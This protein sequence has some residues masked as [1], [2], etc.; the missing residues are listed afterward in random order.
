MNKTDNVKAARCTD[1]LLNYETVVYFSQ[2][3]LEVQRYSD[4]VQEY[5]ASQRCFTDLHLFAV[6]QSLCHFDYCLPGPYS[7][8][9]AYSTAPSSAV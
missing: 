5:Q 2:E 6:T 8:N 4:A 3:D 7:A 9:S 1:A